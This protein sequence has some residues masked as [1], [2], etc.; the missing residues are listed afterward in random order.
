MNLARRDLNCIFHPCSQMK[1]Y[2]TFE[3]L[4]VSHAQGS[5]ITLANGQTLI[6]AISSWWCKSLG[7]GHPRLKMALTQQMERFEQVIF[8]NTTH[9]TIVELSERLTQ[10][11][12]SLNKVFYASEGSSAVEIAL[13]MAIHAQQLRGKKRNKLVAL[14]NGYHGETLFALAVSDVACYKAPYSD[15]I[16]SAELIDPAYVA[17]HQDPIWQ[18]ASVSW[19]TAE[20]TLLP[21][22][23]EIAAIIVEPIVQGA[24]GMQMYSQDFLR[25]LR[26]FTQEKGI[27]LIADEIMTGMGRTGKRLAC[28]HSGIEPDLLCLGKG[29]T[30]G[31]LPFSAVLLTDALYDLF[32]HDY[33][34]S[35]SFLHSH[36]FSGHALGA[37]VALECL[38]VFNEENILTKTQVL[39][40]QLQ[41]LMQEVVDKTGAL[42]HL[43]GIGGIVAADLISHQERLGYQVYQHAVKHGALL[44]PLGNT[45]Y[46]LPPLNTSLSTLKDLR[47][48]TIEAIRQAV[49]RTP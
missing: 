48:I 24:G 47:D 44:R 29:L 4:V 13:K 3:P 38:K 11:M 6:D 15:W 31:F 1:D 9:D 37:A 23:D 45:I 26:Q 17:S 21:H 27:Y 39:E 32:Y 20:A 12:P 35:T 25:R 49:I 2:A 19:S 22:C 33:D 42:T 43:R 40:K 16:H 7:H 28:E 41:N 10:F 46:W 36:T 14:K 8:A 5:Y 18:D 34:P 30:G